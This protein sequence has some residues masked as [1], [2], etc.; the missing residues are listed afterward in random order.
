MS[1]QHSV[2]EKRTQK[3]GLI[4]ALITF[5]AVML[6][7]GVV[8]L[9]LDRFQVERLA[10]PKVVAPVLNHATPSSDLNIPQER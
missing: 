4:A 3:V 5:V 10:E 1:E 2:P 8:Y 7:G 6:M 9:A